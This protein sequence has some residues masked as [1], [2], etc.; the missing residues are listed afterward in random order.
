M[1]FAAEPEMFSDPQVPWAY[2]LEVRKVKI[3]H[4]DWSTCTQN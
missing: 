3:E 2:T 1:I 4:A